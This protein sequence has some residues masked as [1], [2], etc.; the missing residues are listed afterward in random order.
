MVLSLPSS[1]GVGKKFSITQTIRPIKNK[2]KQKMSIN[3]T[4]MYFLKYVTTIAL[5]KPCGGN[6]KSL[7]FYISHKNIILS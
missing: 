4:E 5:L 6:K 2:T 7:T 1:S 3:E